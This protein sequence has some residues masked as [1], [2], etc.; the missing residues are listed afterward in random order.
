MKFLADVILAF[1]FAYVLFVVV[2]LVAIWIGAALQ[3][4]WVRHFWF[5]MA[6]LTAILL[7]VV[8]S[9]LG[10]WCPL[11]IWENRL[12]EG[13]GGYETSFLEHWIHK[14]MFFQAPAWTFTLTY[15]IFAALVIASLFAVKPQRR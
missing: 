9:L 15:V 14:I 3:W 7:V 2:G 10:V 8:E 6:H 11:T 1:H 4:K 13:E 12:R 5:R